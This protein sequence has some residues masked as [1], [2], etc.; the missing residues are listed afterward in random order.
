MSS[1][2]A[3]EKELKVRWIPIPTNEKHTNL[4][5]MGDRKKLLKKS[6][7]VLKVLDNAIWVSEEKPITSD[8][9]IT[10]FFFCGK[11]LSG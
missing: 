1:I 7:H 5:G 10:S 9:L 11:V 4:D 3:R 2:S 8:F 6:Y